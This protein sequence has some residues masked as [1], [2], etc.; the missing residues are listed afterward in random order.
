MSKITKKQTAV[1]NFITDFCAK[2]G[3]SPSVREIAAGL[4]LASPSTVHT[5]MKALADAGLISKQTNKPRA[6]SLPG[7]DYSDVSNVAIVGKVTAGNPILAFEDVVGYVPF[8]SKYHQSELFALNVSGVSMIDAG[9]LDGDMLIVLKQNTARPNDI[10]VAL[11]ED[12]ATVKRYIIR[13]NHPFLKPENVNYNLIDARNAH[14]LG[15]VLSV[16]RYY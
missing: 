12:E 4:N 1:Y 9:I 16:I 3:Y 15:R 6:I 2:H 10:V 14:I 11:L 13:D 8:S 7:S 5:H